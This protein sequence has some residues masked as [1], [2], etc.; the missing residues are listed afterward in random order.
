VKLLALLLLISTG[1][2]FAGGCGQ[3]SQA[4]KDL[5]TKAPPVQN[6]KKVDVPPGFKKT[7]PPPPKMAGGPGDAPSK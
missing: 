1:L 4:D 6:P 5:E 3:E 7:P 2:V